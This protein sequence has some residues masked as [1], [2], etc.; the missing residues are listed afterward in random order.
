MGWCTFVLSKGYL[1]FVSV[2]SAKNCL[3]RENMVSISS[4]VIPQSVSAKKP[5]LEDM[6]RSCLTSSGLRV[7]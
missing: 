7:S 2:G 6:S 5:S 4:A 3:L 1:D